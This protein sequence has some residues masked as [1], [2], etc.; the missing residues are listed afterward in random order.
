MIT[1]GGVCPEPI[2]DLIL[3]KLYALV[4]LTRRVA[5]KKRDVLGF[6]LEKRSPKHQ[7]GADQVGLPHYL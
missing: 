5:F 1:D 6:K 7:F 2:R 4:L 3:T